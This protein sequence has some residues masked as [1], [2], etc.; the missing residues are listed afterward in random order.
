[1]VSEIFDPKK[2][3]VQLTESAQNHFREFITANKGIG[4]RIGVKK[5]GCSGL[6]YVTEVVHEIPK[7]HIELVFNG[8]NVYLDNQAI[9]YLS[10]LIIDY[11]TQ[12]MGLT[13]LVYH[14]PNESARCG[15]GESFT[16]MPTDEE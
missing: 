15:C 2:Q 1:M 16:V 12:S 10:G 9:I 5:M 6:G 11:I 4:I 14:N 3:L 13:K 7:D 8:L